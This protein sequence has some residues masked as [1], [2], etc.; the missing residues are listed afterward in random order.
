MI[1]IDPL[2]Q[3][4]TINTSQKLRIWFKWTYFKG[5][6]AGIRLFRH[7]IALLVYEDISISMKNWNCLFVCCTDYDQNLRLLLYSEHQNIR[8][9]SD[10]KHF[11]SDLF[12]CVSLHPSTFQP[13]WLASFQSPKLYLFS[14]PKSTFQPPEFGTFYPLVSPVSPSSRKTLKH[15]QRHNGPRVLNLLTWVISPAK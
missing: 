1:V 6:P 13:P 11:R 14:P 9:T 2:Q 12:D 7:F 8:L 3:T 5:V 4:D 15:C 10:G